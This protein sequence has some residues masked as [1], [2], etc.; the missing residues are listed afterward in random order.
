MTFS[1]EDSLLFLAH[2]DFSRC[3]NQTFDVSV[4]DSAIPMALVELRKLKTFHYDGI[5]REPFS[6][7][8]R[9]ERQT[10]LPQKIYQMKNSSI[11]SLGIFIVPVGRD[12]T[13]V[14]YEA[15]F[16]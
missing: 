11:G 14:L 6:L 13:G 10:I 3:L 16:N 2:T 4:G 1:S 5:V 9:S 7:I 15:V 12:R 8:F